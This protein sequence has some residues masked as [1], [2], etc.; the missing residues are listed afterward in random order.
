MKIEKAL[1]K[2][3]M[4][5]KLFIVFMFF[6]AIFL[7]IITYLAYVNTFTIV[8][9]LILIELLIFIAIIR[10]AN[11]CTLKFV[12]ANNKL[13]FSTG[14]FSSYAYIQCDRVAI[15]HTNKEREEMEIIIVTRGKI[16]NQKMKPINKEFVKKYEEA[17]VEY[18][19]LKTINKDMVYYFKIIKNGELKKYILLDN[20]Y[21]NC[22]NATYTTSAIDNIK[23]ARDQKEI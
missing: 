13:K 1:K 11:S 23:I 14:L 15:V 5:N 7:P 4:Y 22:V 10:K 8:A 21:R 16:K 3:R 12:C 9:F 18:K 17:A 6:L 20:I 2:Q 19:R